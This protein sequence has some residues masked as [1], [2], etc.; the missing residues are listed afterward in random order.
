[1]ESSEFSPEKIKKIANLAKIRLTDDEIEIFNQQFISISQI[2]QKLRGVNTDGVGPVN[3][4]SKADILMREDVV[5]DGNY[6]QDIMRNSP[7]HSYN[8]F[9]VPKVIE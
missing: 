7:Q 6:A 3:N 5:N 1:M 8:C 4:P 9:V 2:L